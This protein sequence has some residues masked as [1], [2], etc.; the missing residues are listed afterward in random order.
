[1]CSNST[2]DPFWATTLPA[3]IQT[4]NIV[5][6]RNRRVWEVSL[7]KLFYLVTVPIV[8]LEMQR[9]LQIKRNFSPTLRYRN[10]PFCGRYLN[11]CRTDSST[12]S[13]STATIFHLSLS[14]PII[15]V[16]LSLSYSFVSS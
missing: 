2:S 14:T 9:K 10:R 11:T 8:V 6:N 5:R 3:C 16:A 4:Y 12:V 1:M 7:E 15:R 13:L